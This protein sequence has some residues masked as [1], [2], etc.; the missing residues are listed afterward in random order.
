[1][2]EKLDYTKYIAEAKLAVA[3]AQ[4][5]IKWGPQDS[6]AAM[7][8]KG[9]WAHFIAWWLIDDMYADVNKDMGSRVGKVWTED[10]WRRYVESMALRSVQHGVGNCGEHAAVVFKFL[11][12][13]GTGPIDFIRMTNGDHGMVVLGATSPIREDNFMEWA[14]KSV[15]CDAWSGRVSESIVLSV[16]YPNKRYEGVL[17]AG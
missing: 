16:W 9:P 6:A 7:I 15:I 1:M 14:K 3:H 11:E 12:E 5:A 10:D 13:R 8:R 17:H 2:A 4:A